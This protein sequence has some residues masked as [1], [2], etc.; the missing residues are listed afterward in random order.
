[1]LDG[2]THRRYLTA[3]YAVVAVIAAA[4]AGQAAAH[5]LGWDK[6]ASFA[7][8]AAVEF[9]GVVISKHALDRRRLGER[10]TVARLLS[11]AVAAGAVSVNWFGHADNHGQAAFFA[12]MSLLG[13]CV[14]L[15]DSEARRRDQLRA[16]RKIAQTAP[17]YG[18]WQWI[19]QPTLTRRAKLL[20]LLEPELGRQGSLD[21]A[22]A[23]ERAERRET[24]IAQLLRR[25]LTAG[26]D[27]LAAE[28]A[29]TT[30]DLTT[31]A[32]RLAAAADYDGL[33]KLLAADLTP[34]VV[35]QAELPPPVPPAAVPDM[36]VDTDVDT[37]AAE[38]S[39]TASTGTDDST[40]LE[41]PKDAEDARL[42]AQSLWLQNPDMTVDKIA[43]LIGRS[44]R[45]VRRY[46][47]TVGGPAPVSGA[48][49][50]TRPEP[51]AW[52]QPDRPPTLDEELAALTA[53]ADPA[54]RRRIADQV[55]GG[56]A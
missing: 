26:R 20:A 2:M 21:A 11:A 29:V 12:G 14:W 33:T 5:W 38:D 17:L 3:F 22:A 23:E 41:Q 34:D 42:I 6:V 7:S 43:A 53:T 16:D 56:S 48:P 55:L 19:R 35:A 40:P 46:L 18:T 13:Y 30:Y 31:I 32:S 9:G 4:G 36:T 52:T 27:P 8:V 45:T 37:P 25:K 1:M 54:E 24:A 50:D 10:A 44:E 39:S 15:I 51:T 28:I 49:M 47:A